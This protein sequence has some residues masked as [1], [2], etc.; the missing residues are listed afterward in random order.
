MNDRVIK[1]VTIA[2]IFFILLGGVSY[3][4]LNISQT[5]PTCFDN[6]QNQGEEDID[7]G[8]ICGTSCAPRVVPIQILSAELISLAEG[9][10]DFVAQVKNANTFVGGANVSYDI[11]VTDETGQEMTPIR[12]TFYILPAQ[13]KYIIKSPLLVSGFPVSARMIIKDVLWHTVN[14]S[15]LQIDFPLIQEQHGIS[16]VPGVKYQV[17][18]LI[19]NSSEFDF[20]KVDVAVIVL[21]SQGAIQ[22]VTTTVINTFVAKSQR[23]FKVI[24][25]T[26]IEGDA[27]TVQ[28]QATTNVFNNSNFIRRYGTQEEFQKFQ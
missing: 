4:I 13:T 7:C 12:G 6:V 24:W 14:A 15:D 18:G 23:Y 20:D 1:Q 22:S 27:V 16:T 21:D 3:A 10:Y 8:T 9:Q 26:S 17:E 2:L 11:I 28:V 5:E 25:P 19:G